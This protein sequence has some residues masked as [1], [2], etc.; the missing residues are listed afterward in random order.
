V[1]AYLGHRFSKV[2]ARLIIRERFAGRSADVRTGYETGLSEAAGVYM[3]ADERYVTGIVHD[4]T[5]RDEAQA[6]L[7]EGVRCFDMFRNKTGNT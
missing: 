6:K 7:E 3:Q 4:K 2:A 5:C 1:G